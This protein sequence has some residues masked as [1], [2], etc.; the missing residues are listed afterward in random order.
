MLR[1][2]IDFLWLICLLNIA[3]LLTTASVVILKI[4]F[5]DSSSDGHERKQPSDV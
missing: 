1:D 3:V 4:M 5:Q 2:V